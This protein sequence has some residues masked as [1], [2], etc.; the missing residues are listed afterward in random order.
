MFNKEIS[1][2]SYSSITRLL[3][4]GIEGYLNPVYKKSKYLEKGSVID[5]VVFGE[6]FTET[7]LDIPI[8]KPQIKSIIEHIIDNDMEFTFEGVKEACITLNITSRSVDKL[9]T[10]TDKYPEFKEYYKSPKNKF[11][12]ENYDAGVA[13]GEFVKTDE[14]AKELFSKGQSQFEYEFYYRG[15]LIYLK[16]DYVKFDDE[17]KIITIT[18]LKS[19]SFPAKFPE[20]ITKYLYD[21][22]AA[23][24]TLGLKAYIEEKK[25]DYTINTFHWV[26]CNSQKPETPLIYRISEQE[27]EQGLNKI[28]EAIEI[29]INHYCIF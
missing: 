9:L 2:L 14:R 8:P 24:Y 16:A 22:Q 17:N 28:D 5:K 26:V 11:L 25:M 18:D 1:R 21:V 4:E 13:I 6:E 3:K 10:E 27:L 12:K 29:L 15:F 20:S 19:S 7:I 23:L